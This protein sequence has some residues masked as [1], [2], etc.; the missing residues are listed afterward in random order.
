MELTDPESGLSVR[1]SGKGISKEQARVSASYE[2]FELLMCQRQ[3]L[4]PHHQLQSLSLQNLKSIQARLLGS[5]QR[6]CSEFLDSNNPFYSKPLP[7]LP[8]ENGHNGQTETAFM[9]MAAAEWS[10]SSHCSSTMNDFYANYLF[11]ATTSGVASGLNYNDAW[12]HGITELIERDA[13]AGFMIRHCLNQAP[14]SPLLTTTLPEQA[15]QIKARI[16][17]NHGCHIAS[18]SMPN[19]FNIP[20]Y[21]SVANKQTRPRISGKG[22]NISEEHAL[23]RSLL[24]TEEMLEYFLIYGQEE[25][26]KYDNACKQLE[27]WPA[28]K[29]CIDIDFKSTEESESF[30]GQGSNESPYSLRTLNILKESLEKQNIKVWVHVVRKEPPVVLRLYIEGIDEFFAIKDGVP[31]MP[32]KTS[33]I[34]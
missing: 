32:L 10:Y 25:H 15:R 22:A 31:V 18:F 5:P 4:E 30:H 29:S 33:L 28:L 8:F 13:L 14:A 1:G 12:I 34:K 26:Q 27:E 23:L 3:S 6:F 7:F 17:R 19:R 20:A 2:A 16:E 24:E 21:I 9:P 11:M